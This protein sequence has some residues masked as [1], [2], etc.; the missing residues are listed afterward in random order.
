MRFAQGRAIGGQGCVR[1]ELVAAPMAEVRKPENLQL[2]N[3]KPTGISAP[4][5]R[6]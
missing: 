4:P 1:S 3:L 6:T 5:Q 2:S